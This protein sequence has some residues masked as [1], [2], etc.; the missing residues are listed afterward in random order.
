MFLS[1]DICPENGIHPGEM[2]FSIRL[3]PVHNVAVETKVYGSFASWHHDTGAA[4]EVRAER[5]ALRRIGTGFVVA[6]IAHGSDLAKGVSHGSRFLVHL[7]SL[8]GR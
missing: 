2:P 8:S 4:P 3:E 1:F 5:I 7:C 6:S